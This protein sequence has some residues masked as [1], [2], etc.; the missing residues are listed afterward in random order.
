MKYLFFAVAGLL[1]GAALFA[2]T[3]DTALF[4]WG[5][6]WSGSWEENKTLNNRAELK[7]GFLPAGL[8]LRGQA[9]DKRP[10]NFELEPFWGDPAKAVTSFGAGLYHGPSGS[11]LLY[12]VLD[13]WGLSARIRNPWIRSAPFAEN[14]KPLMADLKTSPSASKGPAA[15]AYLSPPPLNL[16]PLIRLRP[17]AAAQ[18]KTEGA[19]RPDFAGGLETWFGKKTSL[20]LEG[21]YTGDTLPAKNSGAWFSDPPPLPERDYRLYALGL[22]F[23]SPV[24]AVSSDWA[25]SKA[26][27]QGDGIYG[28]L[29]LRAGA[30]PL[31][32]S[33]AADSAG[34]RF[35]GRD[36]SSPGAGFRTAGKI[37]WKGVRGSLFRFN[38]SLRG[39]GMEKNFDRSSTG[40]YY[41]FPAPA[42]RGASN[43]AGGGFP[44]RVS[45]ISFSMDRNAV[46]RGKIID[47][48]NGN[49]GL[50]VNLP[51]VP[52][53][54]FSRYSGSAK[55]AKGSPLNINFTG[56]LK[57][58][59]AADKT[60]FPYPAPQG[61]WHFY[62]AGTGCE[63]SWSPGYL[64]FKTKAGYSISE[65][66]HG[67]WDT[68]FSAAIRFKPGRLSVKAA[69]PDFPKKWNWTISWRLEKK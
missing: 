4:S 28:N 9:L 19:F 52:L 35:I 5:L 69:S 46:N 33:L 25:W 40:I 27:I 3:P 42:G 53:P 50:S 43:T 34:E 2:G 10:L 68:A 61:P 31:S 29:G 21:F 54:G 12:G 18:F 22:L 8:T 57:G 64:Q 17:F 65:K 24:F 39:P 16:L 14:H 44:L 13:E 26:F 38:T 32:I 62:S 59:T 41:R 49:L 45:R 30:G 47:S 15:Y 66:K 48:V 58:Q 37:E 63:L 11:R 56:S 67:C 1:W 60:P 36:G 20:L 6:L 55:S 23:N 51:P 7:L